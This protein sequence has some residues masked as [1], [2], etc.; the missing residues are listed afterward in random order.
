MALATLDRFLADNHVDYRR[1]MHPL[2][3]TA[4]EV[5]SAAHIPGHNLAK[6]VMVKLDG[7]LAMV[8]MH[9][10]Q[11]LD[12]ENLKRETGATQ[13]EV[14]AEYEFAEQF[15]DCELGAMPPFGNL[16]GMDVYADWDLMDDNEIAFNA[17]SHVE[18]V[19]MSFRDYE[20]LVQP[21]FASLCRH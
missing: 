1:I 4:Q 17:G 21:K 2:A 15:R 12:L 3:Y 14:A 19:R 16:Y 18:L 20:R 13:A 9:A 8:V 7:L 11:Y 6:T 10:D 5:A